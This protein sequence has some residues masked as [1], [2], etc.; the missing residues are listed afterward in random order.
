MF[1]EPPPLKTDQ[2][3]LHIHKY[4]MTALRHEFCV[5]VHGFGYFLNKIKEMYGENISEKTVSSAF[6]TKWR[7]NLM[8]K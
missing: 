4:I 3:G 1:T 7:Y 8:I 5:F 2:N 6:R